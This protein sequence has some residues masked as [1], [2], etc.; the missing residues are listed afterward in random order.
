M[1]NTLFVLNAVWGQWTPWTQCSASCGFGTQ[2]RQR[3]C[4]G[5]GCTQQI[6]TQSN[7]CQNVAC[8]VGEYPF[9]HLYCKN[10]NTS[11]YRYVNR[12]QEESVGT[13]EGAHG[14]RLCMHSL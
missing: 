13:K 2:T 6:E 14:D 12:C 11:V 5:N 10:T 3:Q 1:F 7:T 8:P 4:S 9:I